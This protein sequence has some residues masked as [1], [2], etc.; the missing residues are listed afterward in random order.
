MKELEFSYTR[1]R[2]F[3]GF[4][5]KYCKVCPTIAHNGEK[6]AFLTYQ[7]LLLS[8]SDVFFDTYIAKSTDG[9]KTFGEPKLRKDISWIEDGVRMAPLGWLLYNKHH[10]KWFGLGEVTKYENDNRQILHNGIGECD[11]VVFSFDMERGDWS[12]VYPL[13]FPFPH[14]SARPA[15]QHIELDNGD[16]LVAFY[17]QTEDMPKCGIITAQYTFDGDELKI[18]KA[19]ELVSGDNYEPR[20]L[21]EPALAYLNGRYYLTVRSDKVGVFAVS[22]DGFNFSKPEPW[23]WDDGSILENYNTMQHWV[24]NKDG[25][26]LAYTRRGAHNDHVFRHRAPIFMARFDEDRQCLIRES[27][28]ILVPE[29]GTRLGNFNVIEAGDKESWL[30]TAEWMQP[31]GCEKYG[32]DNSIWIARVF[33]E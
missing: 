3:S 25:L 19:G 12:E 11:P 27:E 4:D 10:E 14:K 29:L 32:S 28:V 18:V 16:I 33:W 22:D 17:F 23:R 24:R 20:G 8:G 7:M 6:T 13:P 26:F 31:A 15:P 1:E 9:G 21:C 30:I 5:G 2:I